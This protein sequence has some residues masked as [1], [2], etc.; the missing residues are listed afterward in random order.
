MIAAQTIIVPE[1]SVP[2]HTI[3]IEHE[4]YAKARAVLEVE[5]EFEVLRKPLLARLWAYV[6]GFVLES[7]GEEVG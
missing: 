1:P 4:G 3:A 2:S 7:P 6:D 5:E